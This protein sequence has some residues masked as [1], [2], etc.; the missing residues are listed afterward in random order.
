[1]RGELRPPQA[2]KENQ[3]RKNVSESNRGQ[4]G[5]PM[6]VFSELVNLRYLASPRIKLL[7]SDEALASKVLRGARPKVRSIVFRI[8]SVSCWLWSTKPRLAKG[9]ITF[10][11]TRDPS[12]KIPFLVGGETWSQRPPCS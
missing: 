1:M 3:L 11:G 12:P 7:S 5:C 10:A 4:P 2:S 6:L 9:P 8:E